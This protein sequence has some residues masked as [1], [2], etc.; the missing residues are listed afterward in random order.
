MY[1][2]TEKK[3]NVFFFL[4]FPSYDSVVALRY[5]GV[6]DPVLL[7]CFTLPNISRSHSRVKQDKDTGYCFLT[8]LFCNMVIS[9]NDPSSASNYEGKFYLEA[10][11][12]Y[13]TI[14]K[15]RT[16][17]KVTGCRHTRPGYFTFWQKSRVKKKFCMCD[18]SGTSVTVL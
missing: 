1:R 9:P 12:F 8:C 14:L 3:L 7:N 17:L 15:I 16:F 11:I 4:Y 18:Q 10:N 2:L 13:H 5:N 6:G